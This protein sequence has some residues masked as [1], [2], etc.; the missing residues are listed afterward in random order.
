MRIRNTHKKLVDLFIDLLVSKIWIW[1]TLIFVLYL[2]YQLILKQNI[3]LA[4]GI[5]ILPL[6]IILL[7]VIIAY[8]EKGFYPVFAS[9]FVLLSISSYMDIKLGVITVL[10]TLA[11]FML[12]I[13]KGIYNRL[14]WKYTINPMLGVY[15]IWTAYCILEIANPNHVQEAWNISI[16]QYAVYPLV[17]AILVPISIKNK[18][19]IHWLLLIWSIFI[20]FAAKAIMR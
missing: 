2:V 20:L 6:L 3:F 4:L 1:L 5:A 14:E 7:F 13:I 15:I 8:S 19:H 16:T 12:I 11:V 17:C 10:I 9:H 18:D